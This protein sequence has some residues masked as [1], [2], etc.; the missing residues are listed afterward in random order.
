MNYIIINSVLQNVELL[1]SNRKGEKDTS[2]NES[3]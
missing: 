2:D 1:R 3:E